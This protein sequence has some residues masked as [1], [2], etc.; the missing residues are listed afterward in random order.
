MTRTIFFSALALALAAGGAS[1]QIGSDRSFNA[2]TLAL[3]G[4]TVAVDCESASTRAP[5]PFCLLLLRFIA[6]N[7]LMAKVPISL[8]IFLG[9]L[10]FYLVFSEVALLVRGSALTPIHTRN[11]GA[12]PRTLP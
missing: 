11:A 5:L 3:D 2:R 6:K 7:A 8:Y 4:D 12:S 10:K 1:A 9:N